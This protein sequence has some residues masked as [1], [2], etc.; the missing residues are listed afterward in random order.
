[1]IKQVYRRANNEDK[2][3]K[4]LL[5][6][7]GRESFSFS[8]HELENK[9]YFIVLLFT[10]EGNSR[11]GKA[12]LR[13]LPYLFSKKKSYSKV[14][15]WTKYAEKILFFDNNGKEIKDEKLIKRL[16]RLAWIHEFLYA[17]PFLAI[18]KMQIRMVK[19]MYE[20]NKERLANFEYP[21]PKSHVETRL[22]EVSAE[23]DKSDLKMGLTSYQLLIKAREC[24]DI[25]HEIAHDPVYNKVIQ[26]GEKFRLLKQYIE[27]LKEIIE[28]REKI[29]PEWDL[30]LKGYLRKNK[31]GNLLVSLIKDVIPLKL[32]FSNT[33][34]FLISNKLSEVK[35]NVVG[36]KSLQDSILKYEKLLK[37]AEK[38]KRDLFEIEFPMNKFEIDNED[39]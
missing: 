22:Y 11:L 16:Y 12:T 6:K 2:C 26:L 20:A 8:I 21:E 13:A 14:P 1:M 5:K 4:Y 29:W 25:S 18:S 15:I 34:S 33:L 35:E 3:Y 30:V 19:S 38:Y 31:R 27:K 23:L 32:P 10:A 17:K 39:E 28:E 36:H 37:F 9:K 7:Y 24:F